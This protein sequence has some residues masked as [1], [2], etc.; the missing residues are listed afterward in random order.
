MSVLLERGELDQLSDLVRC[1]AGGRGAVVAV[2]GPPGIGK[3]RLGEEAATLARDAGMTV[4]SASGSELEQEFAFGAMRQLFEPVLANADDE[5]HRTLFEGAARLAAPALG[6]ESA[7]PVA[8]GP[9]ARFPMIHGLYWLTANLAAEA[10]VLLWVDDLQWVDRP[11][12]RFLAYLSRRLADLPVLLVV[13]LR[14]ALPGEDRAEADAIV[15]GRQT[16]LI[17]PGPLSVEAVAILAERR[18]G[19]PPDPAFA[20]ECRRLTGGNALL[21]EEM[22]GE[23]EETGAGADAATARALGA[24]GLER[25]GRRVQRRLDS[26]PGPASALARAVAVL[27]DGYSLD[28]GAAL[29]GLAGEDAARAADTLI[30]AD[31]LAG[32]PLLRFRHPLVRAAAADGL[33]APARAAAHARA[34]RTLAEREAPAAVVA[35]HLLG[36]PPGRRPVGG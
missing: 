3:T 31:V 30:A 1:A 28:V 33:S 23:L 29:A 9:D 4:L 25:V 14:P 20:E 18:L 6:L 24:I 16:L 15:S 22:L 11:S 34:A 35:A 5:R 12:Q 7:T 13:G 32:E 21:V 10:A 36:S 26:L 19:M 2:E 27:G 8:D 17:E